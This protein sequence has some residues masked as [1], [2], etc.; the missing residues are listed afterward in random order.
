MRHEKW[1]WQRAGGQRG[2]SGAECG[3]SP[4]APPPPVRE[5]LRS[6]YIRTYIY[7]YMDMYIYVCIHMWIYVVYIYV[8]IYIYI[9]RYIYTHT[10]IHYT[11]VNI[12]AYVYAPC[13]VRV[14]AGRRRPAGRQRSRMRVEPLCTSTTWKNG[15]AWFTLCQNVLKKNLPCFV[16][17]VISKRVASWWCVPWRWVCLLLFLYSR[18]RS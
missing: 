18:Y 11:H 6:S 13:K 12:H 5:Y 15:A 14:R 16:T 4:A 7:I 3:S 1:E 10:H 17:C 8:Y 2:G 9:Y